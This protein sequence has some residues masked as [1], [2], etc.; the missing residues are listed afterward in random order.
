MPSRTCPVPTGIAATVPSGAKFGGLLLAD[1]VV[2]QAHVATDDRVAGR[3]NTTM[4]AALSSAGVLVDV[5]VLRVLDL[6]A[7]DVAR[8]SCSRTITCWHWPT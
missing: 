3:S 4:P 2:A 8:T 1:R 6:E 5:R 7:G